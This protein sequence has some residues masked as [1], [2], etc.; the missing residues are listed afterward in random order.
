MIKR[1]NLDARLDLVDQVLLAVKKEGR[2]EVHAKA[3]ATAK[4]YEK[5]L[6]LRL[7]RMQV[8]NA[9]LEVKGPKP[10]GPGSQVSQDQMMFNGSGPGDLAG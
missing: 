7:L 8:L 6:R 5:T 3:M 2:A 4:D 9:G 10:G 1:G